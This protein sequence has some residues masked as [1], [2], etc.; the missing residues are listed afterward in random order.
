V[1]RPAALATVLLLAV[2]SVGCTASTPGAG[3]TAPTRATA[4]PTSAPAATT[5][6]TTAP[7]APAGP[8]VEPPTT[9]TTAWGRIWDALPPS[10]PAF[11]GAEPGT[12][13]EGPASAVLSVAKEPAP[14]AAFYQK[15]LREAGYDIEALAGPMEDGSTT[16]DAVGADPDCRVQVTMVPR[17]GLSI[18]TILFAA[19]C[20]YR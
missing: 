18:V 8:T 9:T 13:S 3:A 2:A 4:S 11:P 14:I 16:I 6:P 7:G 17:G 1:M 15:A 10:F 5:R 20:P 12:A 19:A